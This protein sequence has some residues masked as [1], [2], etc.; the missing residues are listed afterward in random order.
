MAD[1]KIL[2]VDDEEMTRELLR[3][4]F[5][6]KG[7]CVYEASNA[8]E[9]CTVLLNRKPNLIILDVQMPGKNGIEICKEL[10][11]NPET[12]TIPI[13]LNTCRSEKEDIIEG[14]NAG[15]DDYLIK[16]F[17]SNEILARVQ[18]HLR[19]KAH[20]AELGHNDLVLLLELSE[21]ISTIRNPKTILRTIVQKMTDVIDVAR[22]SIASIEEDGSLLVKV[23]SDLDSNDEI[24]LDLWKYPEI[25][26]SLETKKPV[27]IN[28]VKEDPLL[29]SVRDRVASIN[30]NSIVVV[31][32]IRK[33]SII[34][35]F[36][37]RTASPI[38]DAID[39]RVLNLC[40]LVANISANALEN[41]ILFES[42][43]KTN[44][45]LEELAITDGLTSLYNHHHF[46][47]RLDKEFSRAVRYSESLSCILLDIDDFKKIN[48]TY[49]HR[50]GDKVLEQMGLLI[51]NLARESDIPSRYGGEEFAILLPQTGVK[52]ALKMANRLLLLV[53]EEK[54]KCLD[55]NNVT[56]SVGV[57]TLE[58]S[59]M[60]KAEQ[61]IQ[62]ADMALYEAK[63]SGK[64]RVLEA[65]NDSK[66]NV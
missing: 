57:S 21:I 26:K 16:P 31:P 64:D 10:K 14:L 24:H 44:I 37:L 9:L 8:D 53:R 18:S 13:I 17:N 45:Y 65:K 35:T 58:K 11:A 25:Q 36:F 40:Q 46:Y 33:E 34:G 19:T 49:G 28:N 63:H 2:I 59:G 39:E 3:A 27:I 1:N 23:S 41:A 7:Y 43:Q 38:R 42:V 32:I 66:I 4:L 20:Y 15:A 56:I 22:C 50:S 55:G 60:K 54:F 30:L 47:N 52:G 62:H 51:K 12:R 29:E 6:N 48:D 5:E 61:L